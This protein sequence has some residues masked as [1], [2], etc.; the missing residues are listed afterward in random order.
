[1]HYKR[2]LYANHK[3]SAFGLFMMIHYKVCWKFLPSPAESLLS[4]R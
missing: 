3:D 2:L 1:M 4:E